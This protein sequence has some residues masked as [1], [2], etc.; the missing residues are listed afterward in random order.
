VG[1]NQS[2]GV[3]PK[4]ISAQLVS[5]GPKIPFLNPSVT[6]KRLEN[7]PFPISKK[8]RGGKGSKK[9][10]SVPRNFSELFPEVEWLK[11]DPCPSKVVPDPIKIKFDLSGGMGNVVSI[12]PVTKCNDPI[13]GGVPCVPSIDFDPNVGHLDFEVNDQ[14]G[15]GDEI[16]CAVPTD[17]VLYNH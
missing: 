2:N 16:N 8:S 9:F 1:C 14:V 5:D 11:S 3:D 4:S 10:R 13:V 12:T 6:I 7:P 17:C 15:L